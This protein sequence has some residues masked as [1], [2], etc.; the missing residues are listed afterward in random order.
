MLIIH[1]GLIGLYT[2]TEELVLYAN[3]CYHQDIEK[4]IIFVL[5]FDRHE[6][7]VITN[8]NMTGVYKKKTNEIQKKKREII[9]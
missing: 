4:H 3:G 5:I 2:Y 1:R 6:Q 9:S 8:C 7:R